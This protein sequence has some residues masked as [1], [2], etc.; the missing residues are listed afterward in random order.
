MI[1]SKVE[2]SAINE[3]V[4]IDNDDVALFLMGELIRFTGYA[5][6]VTRF[7]SFDDAS[8]Y[9]DTPRSNTLVFL[10]YYQNENNNFGLIEK[11]QEA[12]IRMVVMLDFLND[13]HG[14]E[15]WCKTCSFICKPLHLELIEDVL[16]TA[17]S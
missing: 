16:E 10:D 12:N 4:L 13:K 6:N 11:I 2:Q 7:T 8:E 15:N 5:G 3:I 9:F 14:L 17:M 1:L